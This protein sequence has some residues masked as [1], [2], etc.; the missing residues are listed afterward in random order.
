MFSFIMLPDRGS[1]RKWLICAKS[2]YFLHVLRSSRKNIIME[3]LLF[4]SNNY[5]KITI[6]AIQIFYYQFLLPKHI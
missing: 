6:C 5:K 3:A 4:L 2:E 1:P